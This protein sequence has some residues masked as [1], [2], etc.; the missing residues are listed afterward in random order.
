MYCSWASSSSHAACHRCLGPLARCDRVAIRLDGHDRIELVRWHVTSVI[1]SGR[2]Y[3]YIG[4]RLLYSSTKLKTPKSYNHLEPEFMF[5]LTPILTLALTQIFALSCPEY[6]KTVHRESPNPNFSNLASSPGGG[7]AGTSG[8]TF[9]CFRYV[10]WFWRPDGTENYCKMTT[11]SGCKLLSTRKDNDTGPYTALHPDQCSPGRDCGG[12]TL[13]RRYVWCRPTSDDTVV[14]AR[15]REAPS[16]GPMAGRGC[17]PGNINCA[18]PRTRFP[19]PRRF[20]ETESTA[21]GEPS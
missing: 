15:F 11:T 18:M 16:H 4:L 12:S 8:F 14:G 9:I 3:D 1:E 21:R 5:N 17:A 6:P 7:R 19:D 13:R 10:V 2:A 20:T